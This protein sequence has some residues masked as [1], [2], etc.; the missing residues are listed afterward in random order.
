MNSIKVN[1]KA[2]YRFIKISTTCIRQLHTKL[3]SI[4]AA[5]IQTI[6]KTTPTANQAQI[7]KKMVVAMIHETMNQ[8]VKERLIDSYM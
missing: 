3:V 1:I 7:M 5:T 8:K 6:T 4:I 2:K